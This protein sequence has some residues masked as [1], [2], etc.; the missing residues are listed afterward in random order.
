MRLYILGNG[1]M[2]SALVDGL[3]DKFEIIVV[4]R[5]ERNLDKFKELSIKTEIYGKFYDIEG[6]NIILAFK[7]YALDE[8]SQI[9]KGEANVCISVLA[10]TKLSDLNFIDAKFKATCMPNI[11]AKFKT[12]TTPFYTKDDDSL[13]KQILDEFGNSYKVSSDDELRVAGVM[14]GCVPAYLSVVAEALANAGVKEGLK[15]EL[16]NDLVQSVFKSTTSL[17]E[18]Y[19]PA[20]LKELVCSPKG[21]TI[22]G[23]VELEKHG[24][25]SAFIEAFIKSSNKF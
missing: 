11:A 15:K 18:K 6:K 24:V 20:I 10:M 21:T 2:A 8:M 1:A 13:I 19:H 7:P 4:G 3:K 25:R 23:V 16:C 5:S 14:T 12:S 17:L 22:E 9:L